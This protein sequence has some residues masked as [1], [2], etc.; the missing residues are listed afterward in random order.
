MELRHLRYFLAVAEARNVTRAA[1]A[2]GIQQ[3]PLS[4]QVRDLERELGY[5]LFRR[6]PRGVE[7][8]EGGAVFREEAKAM[9]AAVERG[10][11]RAA[12][13]ALGAAGTLSLGFTSSAVTHRLAPALIRQYRETHPGVDLEIHEGNAAAVTEAVEA[14]RLDIAF[15]RRPVSEQSS[16]AYHTV[17]DERLL[18][19]LPVGHRLAVEARRHGRER[20]RL[21]DL[22][23]E[24]FILVRRPGAPGMYG[25]LI[26]ACHRAG[27]APRVVAEVDQMLTN[28]TLV[29]AGVG[30]SVV[31]A[32]MRDIHR[33]GVFYA[34]PSDAPQLMAPLNLVT[35]MGNTNPAV[36]RFVRFAL[37]MRGEARAAARSRP[38]SG[39]RRGGASPRRTPRS[40]APARTS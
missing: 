14:G 23:T 30:V 39:A 36:A 24:A 27:F 6:L 4:Q 21:K 20:V 18:V 13:A 38:G 29:A 17:A 10:V 34:E 11:K 25:D 40:R 5:A 37:A 33:D 26:E 31:P 7:L 32:S 15:I 12:Q 16:L 1:A 28:I 8:T 9:L 2:L 35:R 3:P 22:A 19:A